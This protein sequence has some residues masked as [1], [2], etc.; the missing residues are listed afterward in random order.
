M[1]PEQAAQLLT[2][3]PAETIGKLP[4]IICPNCSKAPTKVCGE[5]NKVQCRDCNN[6]ITVRHIHLDYVGH[7]AVTK[8]LLDV[9]SEWTWE[10]VAVD[11]NG[12]PALAN[13][14]LWI[15]LTIGGTSR[16]GWGDGPDI[17]QMI[18]DAIRNAAMRFGVALDLWSKED[19]RADEHSDEDATNDD[20]EPPDDSARPAPAAP[21]RVAGLAAAVKEHGL[22]DWVKDQAFP[23]PWSDAHCAAIAAKVADA[24]FVQVGNDGNSAPSL[25]SG[26]VEGQQ[27][28]NGDASPDGVA[29]FMPASSVAASTPPESSSQGAVKPRYAT[30]TTAQVDLPPCDQDAAETA[31]EV[32]VA[33][34]GSGVMSIAQI[35]AEV[36]G[37][38]VESVRRSLNA[39]GKPIDGSTSEL[40]KRLIAFRTNE[41]PF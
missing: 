14:G 37:M 7:A 1:T 27:A 36:R 30:Q 41:E 39:A 5:H 35:V 18:S 31:V 4:R 13:G 16:L 9:D 3:F 32:P 12:A 6:Y 28:D 15:R 11:A 20:P 24:E 22:A 26:G 21:E 34:N 33:S 8:R 10:P 40:R 2:P 23:W 19:L 38:P 17:K 25:S 29:S